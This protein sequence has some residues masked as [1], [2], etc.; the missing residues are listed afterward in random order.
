MLLVKSSTSSPFKGRRIKIL[1]SILASS[2]F[3]L[4]YRYGL[5]FS[6]SGKDMQSNN[7]YLR[8]D[9]SNATFEINANSCDPLPLLSSFN[10]PGDV[11]K[12]R[13]TIG[14]NNMSCYTQHLPIFANYTKQRL[15][16]VKNQLILHIP[17]TGGTSLCSFAISVNKNV[18]ENNC[19]FS[20][21]V[22]VLIQIQTI[23]CTVCN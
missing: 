15:A 3:Y 7:T 21:Y 22:V 16:K 14:L 5:I 18:P 19:E 11:N 8:H 4:I 13:R 17:K 6:D 23:F 12:L 2:F 20:K 1:A 9:I 10:N